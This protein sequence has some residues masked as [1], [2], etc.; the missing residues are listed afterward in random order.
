MLPIVDERCRVVR[1]VFCVVVHMAVLG[2]VLIVVAIVVPS[3][4]S[5]CCKYN[6][7]KKQIMVKYYKDKYKILTV[8]SKTK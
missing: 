5:T 8:N 2:T 6:K 3:N 1:V 4:K 7:Q